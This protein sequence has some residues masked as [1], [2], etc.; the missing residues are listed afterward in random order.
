MKNEDVRKFIHDLANSLSVIDASLA[1]ASTLLEKNHPQSI[2]EL[3]RVRMSHDHVR[4]S[5]L[6]LREFREYVQKNSIE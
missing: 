1:R 2:E 5:I 3:S 4:K 6:M